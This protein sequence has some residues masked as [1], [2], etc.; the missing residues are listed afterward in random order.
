ML[1]GENCVQQFTLAL[2]G[3][4]L[5]NGL[6]KLSEVLV[7]WMR[8]ARQFRAEYGKAS[9]RN[10]TG[11]WLS[12]GFRPSCV[13][14]KQKPSGFLFLQTNCFSFL[15]E[16]WQKVDSC[17]TGQRISFFDLKKKNTTVNVQR[18]FKNKISYFVPNSQK[19]LHVDNLYR[20][21][22]YGCCDMVVGIA[23][24]VVFLR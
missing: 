18:I 8:G 12:V 1:V 22:I 20:S 23:F 17:K 14:S 19:H 21:Q 2:K 7:M 13:Q 5:T 15:G 4:T 6:I 3:G 10:A 11:D 16:G 9:D 24:A